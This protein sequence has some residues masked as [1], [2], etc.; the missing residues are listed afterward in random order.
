MS[1]Q[2]RFLISITIVVS[3]ILG[4][5]FVGLLQRNNYLMES[6]MNREM[7]LI[8]RS[9]EEKGELLVG[10]ISQISPVA[11]MS[12]DQYTLQTYA[13]QLLRDEDVFRLDFIDTTEASLLSLSNEEG[14]GMHDYL[15]F[16]RDIITDEEQLGVE[17][18]LGS[19]QIY[20]STHRLEEQW[21]A[22]ENRIVRE[23]QRQRIAFLGLFA[24]IL[25]V[26]LF[27]IYF[28]LRFIVIAPVR[29]GVGILQGISESGDL[30][31]DLEHAF[32][33]KTVT[34][35]MHLFGTAVKDIVESQRKMVAYVRELAQ[36][37]W[38]VQLEQK[39]PKD[40]LAVSLN[41]MIIQVRD[42]LGHVR[43]SVDQVQSGSA[44]ISNA[45]QD[46]SEG[47]TNSAANIEEINSSI[48]EIGSQ[49]KTNAENGEKARSIAEDTNTKAQEGSSWMNDMVS[50]MEE[51]EISSEKIRKVTKIIEDIAFQTNLLALNAAVEAA[52]AGQH[53]K[54]F[55]VVA[56]EVRSLA[57]RSGKAA[58]ETR[59]LIESSGEKVRQ[60]SEIAHKTSAMLTEITT[61]V[62]ELLTVI[63]EVSASSSDQATGVEEIGASL[64][65]V[66][67][68]VQQNAASSE[69]TASA[70]EEL[71]SQAEELKA[72]VGKF[73]LS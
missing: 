28:L 66:D 5:L 20:F 15:L 48:T 45:S 25:F 51:I 27:A 38:M 54:G 22:S 8:N 23:R 61:G 60:G 47:A 68:I 73:K 19:V 65:D 10:L 52:R 49:A 26:V 35:E 17:M 6:N 57:S 7:E 59:E 32:S 50:S 12:M 37:N 34:K 63:D 44:Q 33:G 42:A 62:E 4:G 55:A 64:N 30:T 2:K 69:E 18:H 72:L 3:L 39:S 43:N 70:A 24:G 58:R 53:G 21:R 46:L 71:S 1:L 67:E 16:E 41:K 13:S 9:Y 29:K 11:I 36:G 40:E 14:E 31:I 56:E